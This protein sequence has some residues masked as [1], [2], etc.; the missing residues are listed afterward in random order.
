MENESALLID[1]TETAT[2]KIKEVLEEQEI[3]NSYLRIQMTSNEHG[4]P[5]YAFGLEEKPSQDDTVVDLGDF[6]ALIDPGTLPLI[7]GSNIDYVEG[8]H[9]S[10]FIITNP[11]IPTGGGCGGGGCGGGGGG[12]GCGGGGCGCGN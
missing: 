7:S 2:S 10:G 12:C 4:A 11:N 1:M 8:L 5:G 9:R 6:K 3:N